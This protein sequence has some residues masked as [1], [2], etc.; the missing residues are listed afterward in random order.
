MKSSAD[1]LP[2]DPFPV[3]K[4]PAW[5][6][7]R[8][9]ILSE[10]D[11]GYL[12][13][14]ALNSLDNLVRS[15]P[16]WAGVWRQRLALK[17]AAAAT[18][19][20]GRAEEESALRDAQLFRAPG[21]DPGPAGKVLLAWRRLASRSTRLDE[22]VVRPIAEYLGVR[23]DGDLAEIMRNARD[24]VAQIRS[25]PV[26]AAELAAELYR[27]RPDAELLAFWLADVLLAQKFRWPVPVPLLMGQVTGTS[28]RSGS[29]FRRVRPG[30]ESW[31]QEVLLHYAQAAGEACDLAA[32]LAHRATRL[33]EVAP[34]LRSP[35]AADVVKL[36]LSDDAVPPSGRV[37]KKLT[38]RSAR[39]L[40]DRLQDLG[41]VR[42]LTGRPTFR[43]YGL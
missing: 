23:W 38:A 27:A 11:A 36:L 26:L 12:A 15:D 43:L 35:A 10:V 2:A 31:G 32:D 29:I 14:A 24:L 16:P 1:L 13:G 19:L 8:D 30:E 5:A 37:S 20:L 33:D 21:D 34:K 40:F 4:V 3:P 9:T 28:V 39:R 22:E 42:E 7:P 17:S 41:A 25:A 6:W 18:R